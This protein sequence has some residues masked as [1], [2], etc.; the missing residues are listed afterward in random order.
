MHNFIAA[1]SDILKIL[2]A[3]PDKEY[4]ILYNGEKNILL[5]KENKTSRSGLKII[6]DVF[7]ILDEEELKVT[8][9]ELME[10]M[11]WVEFE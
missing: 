8:Y 10:D 9:N 5:N 1:Y 7:G 4:I 6:G 2:K 3:E 11:V